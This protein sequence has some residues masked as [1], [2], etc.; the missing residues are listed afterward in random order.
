M[1][2]C[3]ISMDQGRTFHQTQTPI[4]GLTKTSKLPFV[5][6][7]NGVLRFKFHPIFQNDSEPRRLAVYDFLN[8]TRAVYSYEIYT[9]TSFYKELEI[10]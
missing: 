4:S 9:T 1:I 5:V 6:Y 8:E 2:E 7:V 3:F 10:L